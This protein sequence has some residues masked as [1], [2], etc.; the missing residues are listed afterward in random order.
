VSVVSFT[1]NQAEDAT[2]R[3]HGARGHVHLII[4]N[5]GEILVSGEKRNQPNKPWLVR[6]DEQI[7][8]IQF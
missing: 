3:V 1:T 2:H 6:L 4:P 5:L 7:E 8:I